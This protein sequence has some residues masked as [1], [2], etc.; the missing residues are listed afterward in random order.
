MAYF[1]D[2]QFLYNTFTELYNRG[3][4][5]YGISG[6]DY[7]DA[8]N[9]FQGPT[10]HAEDRNAV[11]E[12]LPTVDIRDLLGDLGYNQRRNRDLPSLRLDDRQYSQSV[13]AGLA[14]LATQSIDPNL[15]SK[16]EDLKLYSETL[17]RDYN[18]RNRTA[19]PEQ[20]R[21]SI[22][23]QA[24]EA[25]ITV[26]EDSRLRERV[27]VT[28]FESR[29]SLDLELTP[30]LSLAVDL[31]EEIIPTGGTDIGNGMNEA[32]DHLVRDRRLNAVPTMLIFTD[33]VSRGSPSEV[34]AKI[35]R[36]YPF[37]VINTVTFASGDQEE[38]RLVAEIGGGIHY[39]ANDGDELRAI[40]TDIAKAFSTVITE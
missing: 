37:V 19:A 12:D 20:S 22:L 1:E 32:I 21:W 33:G 23:E 39:H 15:T 29:A 4:N 34:A 7:I 27:S 5:P 26:L 24:M 30:D 3:N 8:V 18:G 2:E 35:K 17:N 9:D 6:Q 16:I 28:Q 31:V 36:D 10:T 11:P 38:M 40:F 13:I 25:F 14:D